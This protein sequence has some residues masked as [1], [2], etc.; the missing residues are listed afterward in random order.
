ML[1]VGKVNGVKKAT[2]IVVKDN[3]GVQFLI[4]RDKVT[5]WYEWRGIALTGQHAAGWNAPAFACMCIVFS[6]K[7]KYRH[8]GKNH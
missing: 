2:H 7:S 4:P 8:L 5:A 3:D 6:G 1:Q